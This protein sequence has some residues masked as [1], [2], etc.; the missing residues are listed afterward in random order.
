MQGDALRRHRSQSDLRPDPPAEARPPTPARG[1][2]RGGVRHLPRLRIHRDRIAGNGAETCEATY[3][4]GAQIALTATAADER[5][6]FSG[7][8]GACSGSGA[9]EVTM[10]SATEAKAAFAAIPQEKLSV[11]REGSGE[12]TLTGTSPG[13]EF[14]TIVC[15]NECSAEYEEGTTII[16]FANRATHSKFSGWEG[17]TNVLSSNEY[18]TSE[19]EVTMS[20]ATEVKARFEAVPQ[21][22]YSRGRRPRR[23]RPAPRP[24]SPAPPP[25]APAPNTSTPKAPKAPSPSS[26]APPPTTTS[27]NGKANVEAQTAA[28]ARSR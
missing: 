10:S 25:P 24:A 19:C 3:N 18:A 22:D 16:L 2:R 13:P 5:T 9:C 15:G 21:A 20:A 4:E 14:A 23:K 11:Q 12:G 6:A 28:N 1:H 7:W 17:C 8:S 26:P 27:S